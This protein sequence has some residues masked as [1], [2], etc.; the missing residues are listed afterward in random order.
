MPSVDFPYQRG[1][2]YWALDAPGDSWTQPS[3]DTI[4]RAG[5][6]YLGRGLTD[7]SPWMND[8]NYFSNLYNSEEAFNFRKSRS[9]PQS[10]AAPSGGGGNPRDLWNSWY[11][12]AAN[13]P[14]QSQNTSL[15]PFVDYLTQQGVTG[16]RVNVDPH[17]FGKGI[18]L[19]NQFIKLLDGYDNP[20]WIDN[21]NE[22]GGGAPGAGAGYTDPSSEL[23]LNELLSRMEQ[24]RKPVN[25]P[26]APLYQLMALSRVQNLKEQPYTGGEDAA[27]VNRYMQPLTMARDAE[28]EQNKERIGARGMLASSGLLDE[29]NKGTNQNYQRGVAQGSSDLAVRAVDEKQRRLDEALSV[30]A[31]L[32]Q[33]GRTQRN[34]DDQRSSELINLASQFPQMDERRLQALLQ[35]SNDG[36]AAS[37]AGGQIM[38]QRSQALQQQLLHSNTQAQRDAAW[39]EFFGSLLN[40]WDTL[41]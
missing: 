31:Q 1:T 40:N 15:Q 25:D 32:T 7:T 30:L 3:E 6:Q 19:N 5:Q 26:M 36:G 21:W 10:Q 13:K 41:F 8:Q 4:G 39:G 38:A 34:E 2:N 33:F 27:L 9:A 23:Y 37:Q 18:D 29:L 14:R 12:S 24:L 22:Q 28:L 20:I 16:A 35:A 11:Q 17:G